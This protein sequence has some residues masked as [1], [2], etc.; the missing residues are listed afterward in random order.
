MK[1]ITSARGPPP[2]TL[3]IQILNDI[4]RERRR[5]MGLEILQIVLHVALIILLLLELLGY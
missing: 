5:R 4:T 1:S 2:A 3:V